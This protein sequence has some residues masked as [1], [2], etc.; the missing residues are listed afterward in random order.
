[1]SFAAFHLPP[2][3]RT[4]T[5]TREIGGEVLELARPTPELLR[6]LA[7]QL[8]EARRVHLAGRPLAEL[9]ELIDGVAR[10]LLDPG[11][12]LRSEAETLLHRVGG[13]S[14]EMV[15]L[16]LDG[17]A[18]GWRAP[19]LQRL[20]LRELEGGALL[21]DFQTTPGSDSLTRAFGP[22]LTTHVFSGNVPGVAVTSLVRALLV[23]SASLGKTAAAEPILP[24][25]F[26]RALAEADAGVGSC[27][28]VLHWEG[29]DGEL[30]A[31]AFAA[32]DAV[33]AYGGRAAMSS[34]AARVT[35]P[36]RFL[37]YGPHLSLGIV[38]R[39]AAESASE[40][41]AAALSVA[42]FDQQGCVS[43]HAFLV[44][45]GGSRSAR[46]WA[47]GLAAELER[48]RTE[49]PRRPVD[50]AEA[51]AIHG[52]RSEVEFGG[53]DHLLLA[54]T[55]GTSWTVTVE[56]SRPLSAS[57][58]N[59]TVR[60]HPIADADAIPALLAPLGSELQSVGVAGDAER[61]RRLAGV[62]GELGA[63]RV[64]SF[65][66]LPWPPAEWRHDGR[67]A[68]TDLLRWTDLEP[69]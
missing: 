43:P 34:I 65:S 10:R 68:L 56:P 18:S 55:E 31:V 38:L 67:P 35:P 41:R 53:P 54:S 15:R 24:V 22:E 45:E 13:H 39:E 33:V 63:T 4:E 14:P 60:V 62:L 36:T 40:L 7:R 5:E 51:T 23:R 3:I 16:V 19:A 21:D 20:L 6:A 27:L 69:G 42:A 1:V 52:V 44:E 30:E 8:R 25:L 11:D 57:C 12:P 28:A 64:T 66:A 2:G 49:L 58:L 47:E 50:A 48:L 46:A 37:A 9:V 29:G 32:A 59:R 17:M 26:G 61:V